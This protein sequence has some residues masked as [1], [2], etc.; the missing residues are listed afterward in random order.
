MIACK[1]IFYSDSS[2]Q[3]PASS[4]K[5]FE[6]ALLGKNPMADRIWRMPAYKE[7]CLQEVTAYE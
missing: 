4:K 6:L 2:I 1:A 7:Y 5:Q 3:L